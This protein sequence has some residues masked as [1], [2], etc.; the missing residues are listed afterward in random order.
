MLTIEKYRERR[1]ILKSNVFGLL[2]I[3]VVYVGLVICSFV[4]LKTNK[5]CSS[6][7]KEEEHSDKSRH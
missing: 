7:R 6:E 4:S 5:K 1:A 2:M 3:S